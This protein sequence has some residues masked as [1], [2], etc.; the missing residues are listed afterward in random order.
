MSLAAVVPARVPRRLLGGSDIEGRP[1]PPGWTADARLVHRAP[2]RPGRPA[3]G[4][5]ATTPTITLTESVPGALHLPALSS[6]GTRATDQFR[7]PGDTS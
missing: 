7:Y 1:G 2:R 6:S 4:L 5:R 3:T